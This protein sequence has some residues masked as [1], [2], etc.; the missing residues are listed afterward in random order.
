M[1]YLFYGT[2]R[3][4]ARKNLH[5]LLD[6]VLGEY[7]GSFIGF[8]S[9]EVFLEEELSNLVAEQGLFEKKR[10]IVFEDIFDE[11]NVPA[12]LSNYLKEMAL[13]ENVFVFLAEG[14]AA[15]L[16]KYFEKC[17]AEVKEWKALS[18]KPTFNVFTL[19][20][21]LGARDRKRLWI[22]YRKAIEQEGGDEEFLSYIAS[23]LFWQVKTMLYATASTNAA[24]ANMKPFT[25]ERAKRAL[26]NYTHDELVRLS[27]SLIAVTHDTRRGVHNLETAL[28]RFVLSI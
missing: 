3:V 25:F 28:E 24:G 16:L 5:V 12:S 14:I 22:E 8:I 4:L 15:E 26:Q 19:T 1:L 27:S 2:D 13:S 6:D 18:A 9:K 17:S 10:I 11:K 20:D 7:P 23:M 21:A